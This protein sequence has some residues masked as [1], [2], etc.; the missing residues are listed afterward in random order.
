[1]EA[2]KVV[3]VASKA[4]TTPA[5]IQKAAAKLMVAAMSPRTSLSFNVQLRGWADVDAGD[6]K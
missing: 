4:A 5:K 6:Y 3:I 1:M 2:E